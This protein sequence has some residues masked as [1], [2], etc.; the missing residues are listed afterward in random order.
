VSN[1]SNQPLLAPTAGHPPLAG[2]IHPAATRPGDRPDGDDGLV[3]LA[4]LILA[5]LS[6]VTMA[7]G[8]GVVAVSFRRSL[9]PHL[10]P[11]TAED[12]P[13]FAVY[14]DPVA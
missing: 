1:L 2:W 4:G 13:C 14:P 12:P 5:G 9:P 7:A 6:A 10:V 8:R 3:H 11:I